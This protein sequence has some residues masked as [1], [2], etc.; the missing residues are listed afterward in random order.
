[1]HKKKYIYIYI[2][3]YNFRKKQIEK[4][5]FGVNTNFGGKFNGDFQ[6]T[7]YSKYD[8]THTRML[9]ITSDRDGMNSRTL[10]FR[11]LFT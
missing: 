6:F 7:I 2:I 1:M 4:L 10:V 5:K 8:V 3:S 9:I 11:L